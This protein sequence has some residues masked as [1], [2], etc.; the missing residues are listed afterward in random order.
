GGAGSLAGAV[1]GAIVI[2]VV[3]LEGLRPETPLSGWTSNGRWLFYAAIIVALV[4]AL[5]PWRRLATVLAGVAIFGAVLHAIVAAT[6]A[7]GTSGLLSTGPTTFGKEGAL[8][9]VVRHWLALPGG[10]YETGSQTPF[11]IALVGLIGLVLV[12]TLVRGTLRDVLLVPTI[13]LAG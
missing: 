12:L 13:W 6:T 9:W 3:L 4:V 7:R 2:N 10:T 8:G 1:L 5:R 11:N